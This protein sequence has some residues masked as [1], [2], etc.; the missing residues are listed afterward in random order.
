MGPRYFPL[1]AI[2]LLM[3][4]LP[5][6]RPDT[7]IQRRI[8]APASREISVA[9]IDDSPTSLGTRTLARLAYVVIQVVNWSMVAVGYYSL[10]RALHNLFGKI[11]DRLLNKWAKSPPLNQVVIEAGRLRLEFGCAMSEPVPWEYLE[12]FMKSKQD[13]IDRGFAEVRS[14]EWIWV[15][16]DKSRRCYAGMRV[17]REGEDIIPPSQEQIAAGRRA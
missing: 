11:L 7:Q 13:A 14:Q 5:L 8:T 3:T 12:H 16:G 6:V 17:A 2:V 4:M 10:F 15:N 9:L 1:P